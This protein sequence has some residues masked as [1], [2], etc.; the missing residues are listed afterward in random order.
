M[1]DC[2][3]RYSRSLPHPAAV[4][5]SALLACAALFFPGAVAHAA[6]LA[7]MG[8]LEGEV[9]VERPLGQL[10]VYAFNTE[11][12]IGYMVYVVQGRFRATN[13]FPGRY[14]VTVRGTPVIYGS[15]TT[16]LDLRF[17]SATVGSP[18]CGMIGAGVACLARYYLLPSWVAGA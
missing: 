16:A 4:A 13:L 10:T 8:S 9:V 11:K 15:S 7:G 1:I 17:A 12:K 14:E 2:L 5:L 6:Q 18:E 3:A